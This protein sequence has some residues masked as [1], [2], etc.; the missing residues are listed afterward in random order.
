M[1]EKMRAL[2]VN[3]D[4]SLEIRQVPKPRHSDKQALVKTIACGMCGTDVKLIHQKFKGFSKSMYPIFLGHEG[5]GEVVEIGANV[6][7][8]R[9][10]DKVMLP[11]LDADEKIYGKMGSG[12][13]AVSEYAVVTDAKAFPDGNVPEVAYAQTVLDDDIN[14]VDAVMIVTFREVLSNI[15]YFGIKPSD[16]IVVFGCGP[17][18]TT[19]IKLMG[20]LGVNNIIAVDIFDSKLEFA[21]ADGAAYTINSQKED[22]TKAIRNIF[23]DGVDYVLDA[24]GAPNIVTQAMPLIKDRGSVLCYGVPPTEKITIDFSQADYNWN[25][26]YQQMPRK[27]EEGEAHAQIVEWMRNGKLNIKDFISDYFDFE[28]SV[29]AYNKLLDREINQKGII[30]FK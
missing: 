10:G 24:V 11:F 6:K 8:F 5:V 17:V 2:V 29:N 18:G 30:I 27:K 1:H 23:A 14:P 3:E 19:F 21:K 7:S 13:G 28:D 15:L 26:V 20:L 16:S 12:W 25:L 9:V 4:Q 22:L